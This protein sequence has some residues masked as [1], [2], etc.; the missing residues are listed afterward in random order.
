LRPGDPRQ[1]WKSGGASGEMQK[2][3]ARTFHGGPSQES[4]DIQSPRA[5]ALAVEQIS[6]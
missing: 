4:Q 6:D 1:R 3:P 5:V 2:L